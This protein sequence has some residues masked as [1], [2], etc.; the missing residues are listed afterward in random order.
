MAVVVAVVVLDICLSDCDVADD[1]VGLVKLDLGIADASEG[2]RV[3]AAG[4]LDR[5]DVVDRAIGQRHLPRR[6]GKR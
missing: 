6:I 2:Q 3:R 4:D 1:E 5:D